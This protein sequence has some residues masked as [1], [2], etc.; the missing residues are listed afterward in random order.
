MEARLRRARIEYGAMFRRVTAVGT[1]EDRL[2]P[3]GIW[4]ILRLRAALASTLLA[5]RELARDATLLI[6]Q[7]AAFGPITLKPSAPC[8][9]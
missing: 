3:Q 4:R 6:D 5:S 9:P 2:S 7:K 1:L 8:G